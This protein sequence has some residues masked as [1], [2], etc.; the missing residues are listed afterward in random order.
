MYLTF[1]QTLTG[2]G[3]FTHTYYSPSS[4]SSYLN[5]LSIIF[6]FTTQLIILYH[7][8]LLADAARREARGPV[9]VRNPGEC[10]NK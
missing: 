1:Y 2:L 8:Y 10:L 4:Y 6:Y 3:N 9:A 5:H 7:I